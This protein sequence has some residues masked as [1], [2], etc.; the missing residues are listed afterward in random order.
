MDGM[1]E[2]CELLRVAGHNLVTAT[3]RVH[4]NDFDRPSREH[5]VIIARSLLEATLKVKADDIFMP[6]HIDILWGIRCVHCNSDVLFRS[7]V[8]MLS[9]ITIDIAVIGRSQL[10]VR[11]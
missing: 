5:L 1:P 6:I 11:W 8:S 2:A 10:L 9:T 4:L 7:I 3:Q